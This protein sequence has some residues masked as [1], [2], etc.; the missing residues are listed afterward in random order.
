MDRVVKYRIEGFN[1]RPVDRRFGAVVTTKRRRSREMSDSQDDD[2]ATVGALPVFYGASADEAWVSAASAVI[3]RRGTTQDSRGGKTAEILHA[4]MRV[5]DPRQ[6]W[7]RSR[8]PAM[9][10]AFAIAE[11]FWILGGRDDAPFLNVWNPALPRYAG[12]GASYAG[13]YGKRL[14]DTFGFDQIERALDALSAAPSSRQ[15]ILQTW[16]PRSD[17]PAADGG[18]ASPDVPCNICSMLKIRNGRLEWMQIM[19][20]NDIFR[21]TPYNF[22]QFTMI[23][24]YMSGCLELALGDFVLVT[25][26]LHAYH[27][28]L[29]NFSI[30]RVSG[31]ISKCI[32]SLPR[33]DASIVLTQ[34][35]DMLEHLA[36]SSLT[37]GKF[38]EILCRDD[39]P[40]GHADLV[41]IAAAD[42]ARRRGW[43]ELANR[44][45]NACSDSLLREAWAS[46]ARDR[47][48]WSRSSGR[49]TEIREAPFSP[50]TFA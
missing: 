27:N 14:R 12:K 3:A 32:I 1:G 44:A 46:W 6:R 29:S 26:S 7:V 48:A 17:F 21:G 24:E 34:C 30:E 11:T 36:D 23:Q 9:N 5:S 18:S 25:D 47:E 16:D 43:P 45:A 2:P 50:E 15:V 19:R 10:P 37:Q 40:S 13:A 33:K 22:V 31:T 35:L 38:L 41:R 39:I 8:R 20:S 42:S 4:T 49:Q 28:D